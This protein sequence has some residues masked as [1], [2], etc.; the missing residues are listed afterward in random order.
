MPKDS[1]KVFADDTGAGFCVSCPSASN[2]SLTPS[3]AVRPPTFSPPLHSKSLL[4]MLSDALVSNSD[5]ERADQGHHRG[6][7]ARTRLAPCA[8]A[9]A[10]ARFGMVPW[11]SLGP[12]RLRE[13]LPSTSLCISSLT[14]WRSKSEAECLFTTE[15][16]KEKVKKYK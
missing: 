5:H 6:R 15:W 8:L 13:R 9:S 14:W 12:T 11:L 3:F 10:K 16:K 2:I 1:Q 7:L 4:N